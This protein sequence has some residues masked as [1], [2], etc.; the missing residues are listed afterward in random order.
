M[1]K[2]FIFWDIVVIAGYII[3]GLLIIAFI[4][5]IIMATIGTSWTFRFF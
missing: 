5:M 3:A 2:S 1:K 4:A